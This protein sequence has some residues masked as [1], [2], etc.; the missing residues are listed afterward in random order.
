MHLFTTPDN[1]KRTATLLLLGL[2]GPANI[3][4]S[5]VASFLFSNPA[6][7]VTRLLLL[8]VLLIVAMIAFFVM[9]AVPQT[10]EAAAVVRSSLMLLFPG[11][12]FVDGLMRQALLPTLAIIYHPSFCGQLVC[13]YNARED[14]HCKGLQACGGCHVQQHY[15]VSLPL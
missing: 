8:N 4:F 10:C 3:G 1:G 14:D 7:A 12:A 6:S 15:Q 13:N 5:H 9:S 2:V 11:Y